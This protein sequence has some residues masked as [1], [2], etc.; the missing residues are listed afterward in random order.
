[1][2]TLI[3]ISSLFFIINIIISSAHL[4]DTETNRSGIL[5]L[6]TLSTLSVI[7]HYEAVTTSLLAIVL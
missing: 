6:E 5:F 7:K 1:M 2:L 4:I 3:K